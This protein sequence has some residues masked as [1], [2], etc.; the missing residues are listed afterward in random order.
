M[1]IWHSDC[2]CKACGYRS[3]LLL[4]GEIGGW[5]FTRRSGRWMK[6][7]IPWLWFWKP[8]IKSHC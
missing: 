6:S 8:L 3:L 4:G 7:G 1:K 2:C 5:P